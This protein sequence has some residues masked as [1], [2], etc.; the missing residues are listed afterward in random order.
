MFPLAERNGG[1]I[2]ETQRA[3]FA[4]LD[5]DQVGLVSAFEY[6]IGGT[7]WS[8]YGLHN[9]RLVKSN[10]G[11]EI[12]PVPYDFDWTGIVWTRYSFP[13]SRLRIQTVRQRLYRGQCRTPEQWASVLARFNEQKDAIYALYHDKVGQLLKPDITSETT[14]Y[15]D[16]F[17]KTINNPRDAKSR[18][19]EAC[20]GRR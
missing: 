14:R 17:Y 11:G 5:F 16:D 8:V 7:D 3:R 20:F 2:L 1:G 13:D 18:L 4:D 6:L 15:I 19:M 9:I 10:Q 12:F